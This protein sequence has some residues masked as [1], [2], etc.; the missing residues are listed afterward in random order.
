MSKKNDRRL[1]QTSSGKKRLPLLFIEHDG[2]CL[3]CQ[4]RDTTRHRTERNSSVLE[5]R[6][7]Q[8]SSHGGI[9]SPLSM[10]LR[11]AK[12]I[13]SRAKLSSACTTN[14]R[15]RSDKMRCSVCCVSRP[16]SNRGTGTC[17]NS[18]RETHHHQ[19]TSDTHSYLHPATTQ[20]KRRT[21]ITCKSDRKNCTTQHTELGQ[22][23]GWCSTN[24]KR[25]ERYVCAEV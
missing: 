11:R 24:V 14:T 4:K 19:H 16:S 12:L 8:H 1:H 15:T 2:V 13:I 9:T 3:I 22:T 25:G 20:D 10:P 17:T 7:T 21:S 18:Q 6:N 23:D 5:T